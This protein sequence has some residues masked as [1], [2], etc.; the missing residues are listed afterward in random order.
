VAVL[1]PADCLNGS[2]QIAGF[3]GRVRS[4]HARIVARVGL[5]PGE[6]LWACSE[7]GLAYVRHHPRNRHCRVLDLSMLVNV[8]K[9]DETQPHHRDPAIARQ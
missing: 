3:V 4:G 8:S 5:G 9:V 6:E 1:E 2:G 7:A